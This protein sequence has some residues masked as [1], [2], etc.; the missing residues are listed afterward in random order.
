MF[1]VTGEAVWAK[2]EYEAALSNLGWVIGAGA[3]WMA[4]SNFLVRAEYLYYAID[5]AHDLEVVAY[6][7]SAPLPVPKADL[8]GE[9]H[10]TFF[11]ASCAGY[12]S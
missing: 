5:S 10:A 3:E 2:I 6:P 9:R 12:M 7:I 8:C 4:T 11:A 1:Y